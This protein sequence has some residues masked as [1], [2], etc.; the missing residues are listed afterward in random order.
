MALFVVQAAVANHHRLDRIKNKKLLATVLGT[1]KSKFK[2]LANLFLSKNPLS[3]LQMAVF[4]FH[5][6]WLRSK[7]ES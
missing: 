2:A 4:P 5:P 3:S 1:V 6:T 7:S